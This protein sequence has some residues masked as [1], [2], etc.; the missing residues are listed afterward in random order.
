MSTKFAKRIAQR[1]RKP[2]LTSPG[3]AAAFLERD[4]RATSI[5]YEPLDPIVT[6]D[7][8]RP[9]VRARITVTLAAVATDRAP[10]ARVVL[11]ADVGAAPD[12]SI[13]I[14]RLTSSVTGH[15]ALAS[16]LE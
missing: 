14:L 8:L 1:I 10:E 3:V 9:Y 16:L 15:P 7:P 6:H 13:T 5:A 12:G 2:R 11:D 4:Y